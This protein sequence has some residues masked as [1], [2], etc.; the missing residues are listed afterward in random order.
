[1]PIGRRAACRQ[2]N[3]LHFLTNSVLIPTVIG[4]ATMFVNNAI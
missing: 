1:L 3:R 4:H 2:N